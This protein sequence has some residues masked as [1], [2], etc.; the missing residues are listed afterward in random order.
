MCG[1]WREYA[2]DR[3]TH[4]DQDDLKRIAG[5]IFGVWVGRQVGHE[6]ILG[7]D[8]IEP[9]EIRSDLKDEI[10]CLPDKV[11]ILQVRRSHSYLSTILAIMDQD[12]HV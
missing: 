3:R 5:P 9:A 10:P 1:N 11:R 12:K 6:A 4:Q 2:Y 7:M 8:F